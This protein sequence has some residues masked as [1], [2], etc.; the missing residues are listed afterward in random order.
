[1]IPF[2]TMTM[3]EALGYHPPDGLI[4]NPRNHAAT[5]FEIE[6]A[7]RAGYRLGANGEWIAGDRSTENVLDVRRWK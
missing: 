3:L 6:Y 2:F 1:M 7:H 5:V 4:E